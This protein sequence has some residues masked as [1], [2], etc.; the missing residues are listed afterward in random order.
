MIE[1]KPFKT[2]DELTSILIDERNLPCDSRTELANYLRTINYYRF[3]GYARQF[4]RDPKYGDDRFFD[5][6]SFRSVKSVIDTDA[7][8]RTLLFRQLAAIEI[9]IR[10]VLAHELGRKHGNTAFYLEESSYLDLNGKPE[11]I[12]KKLVADLDRSKAAFVARYTDKTIIGSDL[13][14]KIKRYEKVP[15]WVMVEVASFGHIVNMIEYLSDHEPVKA[16]A[17]RISVQWGPFGSVI[18]SLSVLRNLCC[19]HRQIWHRKLDIQCPVQRKLRPKNT[20][21]DPAGPYAAIIMANHYRER[22]DGNR[23]IAEEI[24]TLL[25]NNPVFAEGI[26]LPQ[27]K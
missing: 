14:S 27:P 13:S 11:E 18:H 3:S 6:T 9:G 22:I 5:N 25:E 1:E 21:F 10:S 17:A 20:H 26:F 7:R 12:V 16:A 19:H 4:Q 15:I 8:L 23:S 24:S 2:I